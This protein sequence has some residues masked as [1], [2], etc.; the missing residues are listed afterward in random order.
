MDLQDAYFHISIHPH[1]H[2][3]LQFRFNN[4]SYQFC[5]L[6]FGLS[7]ASR[8][9]TKCMAPVAGYLQL[10]GIT[11]FPYIDNWLI[12]APYY[13]AVRANQ[14]TL[15]ILQNLG[16]KVNLT[17]SHLEPSQTATYIGTDFNSLR[18]RAILPQGSIIELKQ[19]IRPF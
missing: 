3:F 17:K 8:T 12:V 18:A 2:K 11:I 1:H 7:M 15:N 10:Q 16:L 14:L 13:G 5:S 9:F 4:V 19:A 6:P